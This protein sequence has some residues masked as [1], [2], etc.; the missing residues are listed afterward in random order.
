[1]V[2]ALKEDEAFVKVDDEA[3]NVKED[4][5]RTRHG[6]PED[7]AP[8]PDLALD[9]IHSLTLAK[10]RLGERLLGFVLIEARST[11]QTCSTTRTRFPSWS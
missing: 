10:R 9:E 7:N 5:T 11:P 2:P 1:M 6:D 3:A 4:G 8:D